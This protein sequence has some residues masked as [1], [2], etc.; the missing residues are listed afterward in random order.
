MCK[1]DECKKQD[2]I[3]R[4]ISG[5]DGFCIFLCIDCLRKGGY[6]DWVFSI[7]NEEPDFL[8]MLEFKRLLNGSII[9]VIDIHGNITTGKIKR[10]IKGIY[11]KSCRSLDNYIIEDMGGKGLGCFDGNRIRLKNNK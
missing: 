8:R 11:N 10:C 2:V 7:E 3:V 6:K 1:C 5:I 4:D 9:E